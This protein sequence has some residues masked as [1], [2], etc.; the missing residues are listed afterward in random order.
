[1]FAKYKDY[2]NWSTS[3]PFYDSKN[4]RPRDLWGSH[5]IFNLRIA[6]IIVGYQPCLNMKISNWTFSESHTFWSENSD[7]SILNLI[8]IA[9]ESAS[10]K[11]DYLKYTSTDTGFKLKDNSGRPQVIAIVVEPLNYP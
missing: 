6:S 5:G 4:N 2:N 3:S 8:Y 11:S 1:M 9:S 10:G 7:F